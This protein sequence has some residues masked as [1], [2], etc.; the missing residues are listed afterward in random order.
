M[1]KIQN[2]TYEDFK[3]I[4]RVAGVGSW[5]YDVI[6]DEIFWSEEVYNIYGIDPQNFQRNFENLLKLIHSGDREKL[7]NAVK[8]VYRVFLISL[9]TELSEVMKRTI[10]SN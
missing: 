10:C 8:S 7:K 4:Q 3:Q 9:S 5:K 6:N 2:I 1:G